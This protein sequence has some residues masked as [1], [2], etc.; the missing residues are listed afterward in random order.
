[1]KILLVLTGGTIGSSL[2]NSHISVDK[3][4]IILEIYKDKFGGKTEFDVVNP[5]YILSE[6]SS[7]K[8]LKKLCQAV[9]MYAEKD[10]YAGI[11]VTHGTDTLQ[12][13]AAALSYALGNCNIPICIASSN[14]PLEDKRA[15]GLQN[16]HSSVL[17]IEQNLGKG[18][19]VVYQN[20]DKNTYIHRGTR[21]LKS[22][23]YSDN[24]RSVMDLTYGYFDSNFEFIRNEN[25]TELEDE[26]SAL[27][28]ENLRE[29]ADMIFP[30]EICP[31]LC[32]PKLDDKI[33]YV[34]LS[35]YHSGTVDTESTQ[36]ISFYNEAKRKGV[37]VYL[38][39]TYPKD[40][41]DSTLKF[42]ELNITPLP[43]IAPISAYIKIWFASSN[44]L[45]VDDIL[46]KSLA[47]DL[48]K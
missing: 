28:V 1:M 13:S 42:S 24:V 10:D 21:L 48:L 37:K 12:Y 9:K 5:F 41:Y 25:Y 29:C 35:G 39:G 2:N 4:K 38:V 14:F 20:Q 15:N 22:D 11:I 31:A 26:I 47:G 30:L 36:A 33:C 19:F 18:V 44:N 16:L 23:I 3:S 45:D 43:N 6:N 7:G 17:F 32:Y 27:S 34:L 8:T 46:A 40:N